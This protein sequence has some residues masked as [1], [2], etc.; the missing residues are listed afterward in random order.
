MRIAEY[1]NNLKVRYCTVQMSP[2]AETYSS[3]KLS[4]QSLFPQ[5][6]SYKI[7]SHAAVT[8]PR[9]ITTPLPI[10]IILLQLKPKS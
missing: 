3:P 9:N 5:Y 4:R 10:K 6:V 2:S 7:L 1:E 8:A